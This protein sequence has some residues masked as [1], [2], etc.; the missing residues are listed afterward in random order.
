MKEIRQ[1]EAAHS[2]SYQP[3]DIRQ[4]NMEAGAAQKNIIA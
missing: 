2:E 3:E 4:E 1:S